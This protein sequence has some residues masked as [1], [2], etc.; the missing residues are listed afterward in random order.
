MVKENQADLFS[1]TRRHWLRLCSCMWPS[2]HAY[3]HAYTHVC[4]Q[5]DVMQGLAE[6]VV[7]ARPICL[8]G[9]PDAITFLHH[10]ALLHLFA[11]GER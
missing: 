4:D 7:M 8:P 2:A 11:V 10:P 1:R 3:M 5:A 9:E 6:C